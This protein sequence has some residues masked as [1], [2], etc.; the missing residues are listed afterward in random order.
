LSDSDPTIL[1]EKANIE[2]NTLFN[3]FCRLSLNPQMIKFIIINPA[4]FYLNGLNIVINGIPLDRI[5][6]IK[7]QSSKFL[8]VILDESLTW[9]QHINHINTFFFSKILCNQASQIYV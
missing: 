7:K 3:W 5:G 4:K 9:K 6:V 2:T 8:G 1:V